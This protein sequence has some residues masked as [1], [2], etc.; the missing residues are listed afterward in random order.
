MNAAASKAADAAARAQTSILPA[1]TPQVRVA[2]LEEAMAGAKMVS[3]VARQQ[4]L[5]AGSAL[6]AGATAAANTAAEVA[7]ER[8]ADAAA[9]AGVEINWIGDSMAKTREVWRREEK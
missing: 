1:P 4:L 5:S 2:A 3:G 9:H 8:A 6:V 7:L